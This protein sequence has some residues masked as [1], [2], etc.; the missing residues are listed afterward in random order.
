MINPPENLSGTDSTPITIQALND[1]QVVING[2]GKYIPVSLGYNNYFILQGFNAHNSSASVININRS[3]NNIVRRVVA[4]DAA[5]A[6]QAIFGIHNGNFNLLEDVAG[7]GIARK[8]FSSSQQGNYTTIR[9][10]WGRWDGSH[11]VGP[12]MTYT[13]A[14]KNYNMLIE[15]SIGTWAANQMQ[16][17][18]KLRCHP[19]DPYQMCEKIFTNYAVDQPWAVFGRDGLTGDLN[20]NSKILGSIAYVTKYD[21]FHPN[22]LFMLSKIFS[23]EYTNNAAFIE[24]EIYSDKLTFNIDST[25][26]KS[27]IHNLTGIGGK[28]VYISASISQGNIE[29]GAT[30]QS[31]SSI[32]TGLGGAQIC[33]RYQNGTLTSEPLWPWPMN[34]RIID[35]M[36]T[37]GRAS[38]DVTATIEQ[39]F[40][41]IPP[42]C[43][44]A[45][46]ATYVPPPL[47]LRIT[48]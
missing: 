36:K 4:W 23:V 40:G 42:I 38:V 46:Q 34:Q 13:L 31:V 7:F 15:N 12:K 47:N 37:A 48:Q 45:R 18:Y 9:R 41:P 22:Q 21:K 14:Y 26:E 19:G 44:Q 35:A 32:Y 5:D 16:Q 20:A 1:G 39:L 30:T 11:W 8:T 2:E 6:N 10:A 3:N 43:K 17:N 33:Y 27:T 28:G 29:N 25:A 24:K